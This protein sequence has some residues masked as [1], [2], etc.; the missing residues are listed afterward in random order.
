MLRRENFLALKYAIEENTTYDY[1]KLK[2]SLKNALYYLIKSLA[3][4]V[5]GTFLIEKRDADARRIDDFITVL[6]LSKNDIFGEATQK[7]HKDRQ[8]RL[9]RPILLPLEEDIE[10][11]RDFILR[12]IR[13]LTI[14]PF[15]LMDSSVFIELRDCVCARLTL[16]NARRGG[17]PARLLLTE[18]ED[19]ENGAWLDQ[20]RINAIEDPI[21]KVLI[22]SMKITYQMGKGNFKLVPVLIPQ[23]VQEA[24]KMIADCTNRKAAEVSPVNKYLLPST[25]GS[26]AHVSGWHVINGICQKIDLKS[27]E[28]ITATKQRHRVS[29]I[30][31]SLELPDKERQSFFDHMGHSADVN[32]NIYQAPPAI[33]EITKVGRYLSVIDG[34]KK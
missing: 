23:D 33:T 1:Q 5:K 17:E 16:F 29:T 28:T 15:L 10:C 3:K 25:Q 31:A 22:N 34:G 8:V 21:E 32:I 26:D 24:I 30:F 11:L 6:E 14:D 19:A 18:W 4:S 7:I 20:Q 12:T 9:R 2:A 13:N 27:T